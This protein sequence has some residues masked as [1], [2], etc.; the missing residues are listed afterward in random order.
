VDVAGT[1]VTGGREIRRGG[2]TGNF[3]LAED[4]SNLDFRL[5]PGETLTYAGSSFA[6]AVVPNLSTSWNEEQ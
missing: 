5:N 6:G 4:I 1:T 3:Q 2:S